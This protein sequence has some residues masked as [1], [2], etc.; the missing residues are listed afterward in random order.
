MKAVIADAGT[1]VVIKMDAPEPGP[2]EVQLSVAATAINR[3]DLM[4]A[5]GF[6]PPPA[7][8]T[9]VL[10]LECAGVV[11][12]VGAGVAPELLGQR[13]C[14]LLAGGGYAERVT[15][16]VGHTLEVPEGFT[17]SQA[18]ALPEVIAT[19]YLNL[20]KE[21]AA[22]PNERV[23]I[24]AG[25]S[26]IGT[27]AIQLCKAFSNPCF[28]TVGSEEKLQQCLDFGADAGWNRSQGSFAEAVAEWSQGEGANVI[29]DPVGGNYLACNQASLAV[30]G[31]LVL[32]GLMG[33]ASAELN[34][35]IMLMKRQRFIGSTLRA[36]SNAFKTELIAELETK[37]WPL[38]DDGQ[39]QAVIDSEFALD[40]V[41]AAHE[42]V[43]SNQTIGK[44]ILTVSNE[45]A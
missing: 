40:D 45:H 2:G 43:A 37:V 18:A 35:G 1:P 32:I 26:G 31:R 28:V 24:H 5:L 34:M 41:A 36:R 33:G 14:A 44:V 22:A 29:L 38:L 12:A 9:D 10:G 17:F 42:H 19:C 39:L 30:D 11:S 3:A 27:C 4:Q 20:Y 6:Y 13:R 21:A 15:V 25:A 23:L 8:V 16:P 7:G